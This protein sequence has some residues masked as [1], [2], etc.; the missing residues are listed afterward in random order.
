M[1]NILFYTVL[2]VFFISTFSRCDDKQEYDINWPQP[3][4]TEVSSYSQPLS[5]TLTLKGNF[6]ELKGLYFGTVAGE[7]LKIA[8]D[9]KSLTVVVPRTID[10]EGAP[11]V[12]V[13]EYS[14]RF[15]TADKFIPIIPHTTVTKVGDIQEGLSFVVE[16]SNVDLLTEI[17]VNGVE[18]SIISK[19]LD[20]VVV[21]VSDFDLK[22]GSLAN[23][24]FKSLAKDE[25]SDFKNINVVYQFITYQEVVLW[26][27]TD[28]THQYV[29]DPTASIKKGDVMGKEANYFSLRAPG[30]GWDK[31]TGVMEFGKTPDISGLVNPYLTYAIRTPVGSAGYFQ[32]EDKDGPWRHFGYGFNT[33]GEWL[34]YSKPLNEGWEGGS[35]NPGSFKPVL[36]FKAGNAGKKMD[37]DIAFVKITEGKYD[38][39]VEV[40]DAIGGTSKPN[41]IK[42]MDFETASEWPDVLNGANKIGSLNF[43]KTIEPF[44]GKGF[45]TFMD[46]NTLGSWGAYWGQTISKDLKKEDLTVFDNPYLS[47]ALNTISNNQYLIIR[48]Y[49][50]NGKLQM[51]KKFMPNTS[52]K[53]ETFEFSLF[54]TDLENWSDDST[55]L[56]AHYKSLKRLNSNT[57]I[58]RIEIIIGKNDLN[59]VGISMDEIVITEGPRFKN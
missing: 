10:P 1:K 5:S 54:Q 18:A 40:G 38:S 4:I 43:R 12:A 36:G 2:S 31:Y 46:D 23:V 24:S 55:D 59:P 44:I 49:Q 53:W 41:L 3:E 50:Y 33:G 6:L 26:D 9:G 27:F 28:G 17:L 48:I 56:G 39:S 8:E 19:G 32:M 25:L 14:Q 42:V 58:D 30:Y 21:S 47:F 11:I 35:F 52:E 51:V 57:P 34:L 22:V 37:I 16:G 29:G 15:E 7:K 13:N 45:Y 20:K